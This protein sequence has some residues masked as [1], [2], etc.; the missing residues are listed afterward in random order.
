[1]VK[2]RLNLVH[3]LWQLRLRERCLSIIHKKNI[4]TFDRQTFRVGQ[5]CFNSSVLL[6][7]WTIHTFIME[8]KTRMIKLS[9]F[10]WKKNLLAP[11]SLGEDQMRSSTVLSIYLYF[12]EL[13]LAKFVTVSFTLWTIENKEVSLASNVVEKYSSVERLY[14]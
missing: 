9:F 1:M 8:N 7:R 6:R 2:H 11:F 3:Y 4:S 14:I 13:Y 5:Y 10:L 12:G